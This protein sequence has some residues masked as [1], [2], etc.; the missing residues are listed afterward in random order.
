MPPLPPEATSTATDALAAEAALRRTNVQAAKAPVERTFVPPTFTIKELYDAIP[1]HCF[2]RNTLRSSLHVLEDL[3]LIAI[4]G[5]AMWFTDGWLTSLAAPLWAK[6]VAWSVYAYV[7]GVVATGIWVIAHECGHQAFSPSTSINYG[8]GFV[9]HTALLVPFHSWR[10]THGMHHA[11]TGHMTKDQVFVPKTR[12]QHGLADEQE[13]EEHED[14]IL[15]ETPIYSCLSVLVMLL[16]G[17]PLYLLTNL[18]GQDYGRWTSH[19]LPSSPVFKERQSG[20]VIAST[21]GLLAMLGLL[22]WSASY[23][24]AATVALYYGAPYLWVNAWLVTITY[25]QHTDPVLP[26][27]RAPAWDFVRGALCTVDRD[28]G[29]LLNA[30]LHHIHDTH[31]CHHLFSRMPHYNAVEATRHLREKLGPQYYVFDRTPIIKALYRSWR[32]CRYVE[33]TGDVLFFRGIN[34]RRVPTKSE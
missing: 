27:Y 24:G 1:A 30:R 33:N 34:E 9:L 23:F 10:I 6:A 11:H 15:R 29:W 3:T 14:S 12:A 19:F 28:F 4:I 7:Q 5:T 26:H 20:Q 32:Q 13:N 21:L 31:V 17:W 2:E 25:L 16:V 18:S 22:G 8:V